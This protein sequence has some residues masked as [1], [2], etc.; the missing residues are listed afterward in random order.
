MCLLILCCVDR[1][2]CKSF[3][4]WGFVQIQTIFFFRHYIHYNGDILK[5]HY[6]LYE[7]VFSGRVAHHPTSEVVKQKTD[8]PSWRREPPLQ[9]GLHKSSTAAP[10]FSFLLRTHVG[11]TEDAL[12][13]FPPPIPQSTVAGSCCLPALRRLT[14]QSFS[15]A[16]HHT[17]P[18][19]EFLLRQ[20]PV[21]WNAL[22]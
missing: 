14:V 3:S 9:F 12:K 1:L 21:A 18:T 7:W 4:Y 20:L 8:L 2:S 11:G 15:M 19:P 6:L 17:H 22:R 10:K 16:S 5:F 13:V